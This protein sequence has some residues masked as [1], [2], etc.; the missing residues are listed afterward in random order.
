MSHN[1]IDVNLINI[2]YE[3]I[4]INIVKFFIDIKFSYPLF[5]Y[6]DVYKS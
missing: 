1:I 6:R 2:N 4:F 5:M 3:K